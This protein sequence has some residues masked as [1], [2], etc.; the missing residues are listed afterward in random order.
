LEGAKRFF[1]TIENKTV[2]TIIVPQTASRLNGLKITWGD[3]VIMAEDGV[4]SLA[5]A[6][7]MKPVEDV[8][9]CVRN[10]FGGISVR[11]GKTYPGCE[12]GQIGPGER[13]DFLMQGRVIVNFWNPKKI[14][15]PKIYLRLR[16]NAAKAG[17]PLGGLE[18]EDDGAN[19][20]LMEN[21]I[22]MPSKSGFMDGKTAEIMVVHK[23]FRGIDEERKH[24]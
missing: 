12:A 11:G 16:C 20:M 15:N 13:S 14:E 18:A 6:L 10:R 9:S 23:D 19:T 7:L 3:L 4:Q 24:S 22:F 21:I 5:E 2:P 1:G 17:A 8:V